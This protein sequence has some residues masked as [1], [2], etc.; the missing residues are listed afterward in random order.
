MEICSK[1]ALALALLALPAGLS[2]QIQETPKDIPESDLPKLPGQR[3]PLPNQY[4]LPPA[5][6]P[7]VNPVYIHHY[8]PELILDKKTVPVFDF[9][10]RQGGYLFPWEG[11]G[12]TVTGSKQSLPGLAGIESGAVGVGQ[13]F[14]DL[15]VQAAVTA[16]KYGYM[17]GLT[18]IYGV[19]ALAS[20]D[21]SPKVSLTV[22]GSFY[23][24][25]AYL[26][27]AMS[28]YLVHDNFGGYLTFNF[29]PRWGV[30]VGVSA[31]RNAA[32]NRFEARPNVTPF[33]RA[34]GAKI[35]VDVGGILYEVL[36]NRNRANPGNATIGPP[37]YMGPPA[38]RPHD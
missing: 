22:Y 5:E 29:N 23:S 28:S 6:T 9:D 14:G 33:F 1:A 19:S 7:G 11:G 30:D 37:V 26:S 3:A 31:E 4:G 36:R 34:G 32:T 35:G 38:V 17:N 18:T 8:L 15:T 20:Y 16:D 2:A 25:N 27:A 21:F 24:R 12:V 10:T 13:T